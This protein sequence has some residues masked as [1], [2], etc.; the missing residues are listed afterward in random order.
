MRDID[1]FGVGADLNLEHL[2]AFGSRASR[3]SPICHAF[4]I[5][6][7]YE[8]FLC[9]APIPFLGGS[10]CRFSEHPPS[11]KSARRDNSTENC[12]FRLPP[13]SVM[14][15]LLSLLLHDSYII[16]N[17]MLC[18]TIEYY[19]ILLFAMVSSQF[20][21]VL[22]RRGRVALYLF[23]FAPHM[24][25]SIWNL[26]TDIRARS[27]IWLWGVIPLPTYFST[28]SHSA[29]VVAVICMLLLWLK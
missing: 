22:A 12:A 18:V 24:V 4:Q 27:F 28:V 1:S 19:G 15:P 21:R 5:C 29:Q 20:D 23:D 17:R 26:V 11:P 16:Y 9:Q 8:S 14:S 13:C 6:N 10:G 2:D 3:Q 25:Q 7:N